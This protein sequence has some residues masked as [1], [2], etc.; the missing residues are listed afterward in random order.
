VKVAVISDSRRSGGAATAASR[1][2]DGVPAFQA[3]WFVSR[4]SG[5]EGDTVSFTDPG[6][7]RRLIDLCFAGLPGTAALDRG[8]AAYCNRENLLRLIEAWKPDVISLHSVNQWSG[9][10]LSLSIAADLCRI[11]PVAW[12]LHDLW[13]LTGYADYPEEF[14]DPALTDEEAL[15]RVR[16]SGLLDEAGQKR[17]QACGGRLIFIAPSRWI[18]ALAQQVYGAQPEVVHIPHGVDLNVFSPL[19]AGSAREFLAL[20]KEGSYVLAAAS[21]LHAKRKGMKYLVEALGLLRRPVMLLLA[22][23]CRERIEWP[24][25]VTP[26]ELGVLS[27]E[28]LLRLAYCAADLVAVPSL[29]EMFGLVVIEAM[30]CGTPVV[31]FQTGGIAEIVRPGETGALAGRGNAAGLAEAMGSMLSGSFK[32]DRGIGA[33]CR[34]IASREYDLCAQAKAYTTVYDRMLEAS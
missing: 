11:A 3:R 18:G 15:D 27:D 12:T 31:G 25:M 19:P 30:A 4:S 33:Q 8:L 16:R 10:K 21:H 17:L 24:P 22:G 1:V 13:P 9:A 28:R 29:A 6:R 5:A 2:L 7:L 26:I 34:E 32:K 20:P 14:S 23:N